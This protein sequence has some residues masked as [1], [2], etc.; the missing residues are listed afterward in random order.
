MSLP[1]LS[2]WPPGPEG[3]SFPHPGKAIV[4]IHGIFS[5]HETFQTMRDRLGRIPVFSNHVRY[6]YY[7]YDFHDALSA[8]GARFAQ[9]LSRVFQPR[10][11]VAIVAHSM[12][13]LVA[14]LAVLS[15]RMPFLRVVFLLGTPNSGAIR[16]SQL[17]GL[18]RMVQASTGVFFALFSRRSGITDLTRAALIIQNYDRAGE[19]AI[20]IDYVSIPGLYFYAERRPWE[21]QHSSAGVAFALWDAVVS[22]A[23]QVGMDIPHDGIVEETSNDL[24]DCPSAIWHEKINSIGDQRGDDPLTYAHVKPNSCR[25]LNHVQIHNDPEVIE[26]VASIIAVKFGLGGPEAAAPAEPINLENWARRFTQAEKF[27]IHVRLRR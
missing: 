25:T 12:G 26:A 15:V 7:D 10:D 20:E 3:T 9:E 13:G 19:N 21:I 22:R 6:F 18:S 23:L 4:F 2:E 16:L 27:R 11:E 17:T 24:F 1:R 14:R 5:S 8:N